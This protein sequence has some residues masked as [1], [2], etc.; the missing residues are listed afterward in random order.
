[1]GWYGSLTWKTVD[2]VTRAVLAD[3]GMESGWKVKAHR[4]TREGGY[5]VLWSVVVVEGVPRIRCDLMSK[6]GGEWGYKPMGESSGPFYYSCPLAFL[7]MAPEVNAEWRKGVRE[8]HAAKKSAPKLAPGAVFQL[9]PTAT[10]QGESIGGLKVRV[11]TA[12]PL[13]VEFLESTA[14]SPGLQGM[15]SKVPRKALVP[16]APE[17]WA[18]AG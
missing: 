9:A 5:N 4:R 14:K 8:F 7:D 10:L 12:R 17:G 13:V 1:M 16:V 2:D 3:S 18:T 15:H 11:V 6:E